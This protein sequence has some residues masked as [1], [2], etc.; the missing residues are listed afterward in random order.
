MTDKKGLNIVLSNN[1]LLNNYLKLTDV[2]MYRALRNPNNPLQFNL[3][4]FM[5]GNADDKGVIT[6]GNEIDDTRFFHTFS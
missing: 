5:I 4:P 6:F 3:G 1:V 2:V